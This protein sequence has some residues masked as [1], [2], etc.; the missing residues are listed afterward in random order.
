[1]MGERAVVV[2]RETKDASS[3]P[4][5]RERG[6]RY[7]R[8]RRRGAQVELQGAAYVSDCV[9]DEAQRVPIQFRPPQGF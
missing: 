1:M 5:S 3:G 8:G 6:W 9:Q 4:P 7:G 2:S